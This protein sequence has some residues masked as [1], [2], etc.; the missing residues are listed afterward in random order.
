[1]RRALKDG[2]IGQVYQV[3]TTHHG[4]SIFNDPSPWIWEE[5][6]HRVLLYEHA[7]HFL[8]LHAYFA[9]RVRTLMAL[10]TQVDEHLNCTTRINALVEHETGVIGNIDLQLFASSNYTQVEVFGTANDALMQ[11]SPEGHRIYS[12]RVNPFDEMFLAARRTM[13]F[14]VPRLSEK[15]RPPAMPRKSSPHYRL[16]SEFVQVIREGST[17]V[18]VSID[19]VLPTMELLEALSAYEE[20]VPGSGLAVGDHAAHAGHAV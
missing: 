3:D 11:F 4:E 20:R 15:V 17:R 9:G 14:V 1:V 2:Q 13:Q 5:R 19:D 10:K 18:P 16:F 7:I 8:D 6:T 12:G